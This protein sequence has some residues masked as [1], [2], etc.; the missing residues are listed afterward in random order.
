MEI[1]NFCVLGGTGFVGRH[2]ISR[3]CA[4]DCDVRVPTRNVDRAR[5][6]LVF[7]THQVPAGVCRRRGPGLRR[8]PGQPGHLLNRTHLLQANR[9]GHL[10]RVCL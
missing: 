8:Q 5:H 4:Q 7:T 2:L 1:K 3:L 9:Y 6:L 10:R